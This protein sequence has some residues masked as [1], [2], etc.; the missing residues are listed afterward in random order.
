MDMKV[1]QR[2]A[3][4]IVRGMWFFAGAL[5][6]DAIG[7]LLQKLLNY[8]SMNTGGAVLSLLAGILFTYLAVK[9]D[10]QLLQQIKEGN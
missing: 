9:W 4:W 7:F 6:M 10:N 8:Q 2:P 3:I 1:E 5:T